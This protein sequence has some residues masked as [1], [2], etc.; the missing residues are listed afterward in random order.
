MVVAMPA[1][2]VG[3]PAPRPEDPATTAGQTWIADLTQFGTTVLVLLALLVVFGVLTGR[4]ASRRITTATT[5][6]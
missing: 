5:P 3:P 2:V 4:A 1:P 6:A